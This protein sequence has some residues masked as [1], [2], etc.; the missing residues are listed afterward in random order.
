MGSVYSL[1]V[2]VSLPIHNSFYSAE[3]F[4]CKGNSI[5]TVL[6]SRLQ[7]RPH[8]VGGK[9]QY[10]TVFLI[11]VDAAI[12]MLRSKGVASEIGQSLRRLFACIFECHVSLRY[13]YISFFKASPPF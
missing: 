9:K 1:S 7:A 13:K 2:A 10:C 4:R 11:A 6:I 12:A 8:C 5:E 3:L